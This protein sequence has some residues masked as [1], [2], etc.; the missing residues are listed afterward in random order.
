[1]ECSFVRV[2]F[3]LNFY[4]QRS[5]HCHLCQPKVHVN[6]WVWCVEVNPSN[7]I[8]YWWKITHSN[9][10]MEFAICTIYFF[11]KLGGKHRI[12]DYYVGCYR[13]MFGQCSGRLM[14]DNRFIS[15]NS[16]FNFYFI[17]LFSS[18]APPCNKTWVIIIMNLWKSMNIK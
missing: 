3:H 6:R 1:M 9:S 2:S 15:Y 16:F 4:F 11:R 10:K 14:A 12:V 13:Y 18:I 8:I 17:H 7:V 5:F